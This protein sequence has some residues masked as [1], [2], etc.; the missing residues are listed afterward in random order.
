MPNQIISSRQVKVPAHSLVSIFTAMGAIA[1]DCN[2]AES[3][4]GLE[5]GTVAQLRPSSESSAVDAAPQPASDFASLERLM[6]QGA[7]VRIPSI[8]DTVLRDAGG[9]RSDLA[10]HGIGFQIVSLNSA[11]YDLRGE[12]P[13][14]HRK[15]SYNGQVPTFAETQQLVLT[16]DLGQHGNDQSQLIFSAVTG[17]ASWAPKGP[18]ADIALSRLAYFTTFNNRQWELKAGYLSNALEFVGLYVG[19][20]LA[21]GAQGMNSII[22]FQ[23]GLS[24]LPFAT[25]GVNLTYNG[26]G[27][28]YNKTGIQRSTSPYGAEAEESEHQHGLKW[29][30]PGSGWLAINEIGVKQQASPDN[31]SRWFRIGGILNTSDYARFDSRQRSSNNYAL[32]AAGDQQIS[33]PTPNSSSAQG[34]YAGLS[35]HL[36]PP[37][38]NLYTKFVEARLYTI[39][40]F[41]SRPYDML[42]A[43]VTWSDFS[44]TA[45][46]AYGK[47]GVD[48][49]NSSSAAMVSYMARLYPG[50]YLSTGLSFIRSPSFVPV[51]KNALNLLVGLNMFM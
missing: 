50:V 14:T 42:S 1:W 20:S 2:A 38:Q 32:Y 8:R 26:S 15:Q 28:F 9:F 46:D 43:T 47:R 37:D 16:Y 40:T 30:T 24:R 34:W 44:D 27:G 17:H 45:K 39:G 36:A 12:N 25:P 10:R 4:T 5:R 11:A 51:D 19:G 41:P 33:R 48:T 7:L 6:E 13:R 35:L 3:R 22:P 29:K 18:S 23:V 31:P 49:A 21:V